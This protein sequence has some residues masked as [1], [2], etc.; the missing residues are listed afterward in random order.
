MLWQLA[1]INKLML[2]LFL[3]SGWNRKTRN[4]TCRH[5]GKDICKSNAKANCKP[6]LILKKK[7]SCLN[8]TMS[9]TPSDGVLSAVFGHHLTSMWNLCS[10]AKA[11]RKDSDSRSENPGQRSSLSRINRNW[12][13]VF[14]LS[15]SVAFTVHLQQQ[16]R[17]S[18]HHV[19]IYSSSRQPRIFCSTKVYSD[20]ICQTLSEM[21]TKNKPF[22][23]IRN[24]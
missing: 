17:H 21:H 4:R 3:T 5:Q 19:I 22:Y 1:E 2:I 15:V 16:D 9:P 20:H 18:P 24:C 23:I 6:I 7:H 10:K 12:R 14:V 13:C 11:A 8:L